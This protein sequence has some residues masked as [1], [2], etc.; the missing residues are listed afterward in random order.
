MIWI[1]S[2]EPQGTALPSPVAEK[3]PPPSAALAAK[4]P[5]PTLPMTI[6]AKMIARQMT[7]STVM[8]VSVMVTLFEPLERVMMVKTQTMMTTIR[9]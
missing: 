3:K 1:P 4:A 5:S 9:L 8:M 6:G 7:I 2:S